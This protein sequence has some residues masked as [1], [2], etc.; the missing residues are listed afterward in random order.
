M[1]LMYLR[2]VFVARL[3]NEGF[4]GWLL[5]DIK[6]HLNST[7]FCQAMILIA[8]TVVILELVGSV[9]GLFW[10]GCCCCYYG[11]AYTYPSYG[12]YGSYPTYSYPYG[13]MTIWYPEALEYVHRR[14]REEYEIRPYRPRY[15]P[16]YSYKGE[17]LMIYELNFILGIT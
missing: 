7:V 3:R 6:P 1:T 4:Q 5:P 13:G 12:Y 10:G 9:G 2:V 17:L 8:F 15:R 16:S 11:G 14:W